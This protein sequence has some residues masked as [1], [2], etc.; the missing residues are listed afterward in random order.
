MNIK[1]SEYNIR[2]LKFML[3][4]IDEYETGQEGLGKLVSNLEA[5]QA[6]LENPPALFNESFEPLWGHLEVTHA[7]MLDEERKSPNETDKQ[8]ITE[9]ISE[10]KTLINSQ[11]M[12]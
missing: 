10:L 3:N 8:I 5:L 6:A 12:E 4:F 1:T 9:S 11:L 7:M 2:Q